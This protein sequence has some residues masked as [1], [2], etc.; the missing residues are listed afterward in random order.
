MTWRGGSCQR[1]ERK[2]LRGIGRGND[3]RSH[4]Q[5]FHVYPDHVASESSPVFSSSSRG[6]GSSSS[7]SSFAGGDP[8]KI[9]TIPE[10][11]FLS[12][13][14][15]NRVLQVTDT[16]CAALERMKEAGYSFS[17]IGLEDNVK[18]R[19]VANTKRDLSNHV[20]VSKI[21]GIISEQVVFYHQK[22]ICC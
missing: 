9:A 8:K 19:S 20:E 15:K 6:G 7:S 2:E 3:F 13:V 5:V 12:E 16:I 21:Q 11:P 14:N 10:S 22:L 18:D 17:A 4:G 1:V